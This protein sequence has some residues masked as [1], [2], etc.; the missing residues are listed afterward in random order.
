[1]PRKNQDDEGPTELDDEEFIAS[2]KK[3]RVVFLVGEITKEKIA[4]LKGELIEL[5]TIS[6]EK[7]IILFIN[8]IGGDFDAALALY[9]LLTSLLKSSVVGV[10][11]AECSSAA[12]IALQGCKKR[13][14]VRHSTFYI[15]PIGTQADILYCPS[16]D[17]R[18][19]A[20]KKDLA[21]GLR[22]HNNILKKHSK[23]SLREISQSVFSGN[24][25]GTIFSAQEAL[26]KGLIDEIAEG[27]KYKIF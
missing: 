13:I 26:K 15:H 4:N 10:V 7:E 25:E 17:T 19:E 24:G 1:M 12:L 23:M 9:D 11:G 3:R 6:S 2:F 8:S 14:A 21:E 16:I 20:I 5:S 18:M 27:D 22:Q